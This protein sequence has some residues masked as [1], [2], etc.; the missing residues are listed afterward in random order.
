[1]TDNIEGNKLESM[2]DELLH[3]LMQQISVKKEWI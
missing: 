1:M 3:F 2:K